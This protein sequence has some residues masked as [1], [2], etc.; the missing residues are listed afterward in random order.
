[1]EKYFLLFIFC[2]LLG[3]STHK[4]NE[5]SLLESIDYS[6][7]WHHA[8][9][10]N[11]KI[12]GISLD[13]WYQNI[14]NKPKNNSIIVA[15]LDTQMDI[16]NL[17]IKDA[18]WINTREIQNNNIDDDRN[19]YVD[20]INGWNYVI[21]KNNKTFC[22]GN[23]E[24][25]RYVIKWK[26]FFE[27]Q[28]YKGNNKDTL[29]FKE[30][31]DR[32]KVKLENDDWYYTNWKKSLTFKI[33]IYKKMTDTL[34]HFF[35][36]ENYTIAQ[37]DSMY[38]KYKINDKSFIE[39]RDS[40]D[41]DLGALIDYKIIDLE[42]NQDLEKIKDAESQMDSILKFNLGLDFDDMKFMKSNP[43]GINGNNKVND[44][45]KMQGHATEVASVIA[46]KRNNKIGVSGFHDNIKIMPLSIS[47]SGDEHDDNIANAINY[48]VNN[49]AK[50]INMS[51]TKE[52]SLN[53]KKVTEALKYAESK[54]VLVVHVAG[55]IR[56]NIDNEQS[57]PTDYDYQNKKELVSNF[58]NVGSITK[59]VTEK[60]VSSFSNFGKNNVDI[61]APGSEIKVASTKNEYKF[62]SGTS[63][64]GP[65][66]SSTAALIWLYYP[67]LSA[68]QV[69]EIIMQSG[70]SYDIEV[71]VPGTKDKK[72]KFSELS[73]SGK[74]LNVYNA[75]LL[76]EKVN[77]G[78]VKI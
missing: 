21:G 74:V 63:L 34:K 59:N 28:E 58:I 15:I 49:G 18:I 65:M 1:M 48:A 51:F 44:L 37:L 41:T 23:F 26:D 78:K 71:I 42:M 76:A 30:E 46:A 8:D 53:Q 36:K 24:H 52:F 12:P 72:V 14:H 25:T 17:D 22:F 13:K 32:A 33:S 77:K 38:Q 19:G 64:A 10:V 57:F 66:V 40:N 56:T 11:N 29:Y 5:S 7:E 20:D 27:Q 3:C 4:K 69:K 9:F 6:V 75:M 68:S 2:F 43:N 67:K 47:I 45:T 73:K 61:F 16:N 62:D 50:V 55:N 39:R 70:I 31:Y 35:P 54:N 60:F